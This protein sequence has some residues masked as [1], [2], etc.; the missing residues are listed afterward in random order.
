MLPP[1][2]WWRKFMSWR[3]TF[4][5]PRRKSHVSSRT[6]IW[7]TEYRI[8]QRPEHRAQENGRS[9]Q[10]QGYERDDSILRGVVCIY[11]T[12]EKACHATVLCESMGCQGKQQSHVDVDRWHIVTN[13]VKFPSMM[14]KIW[15][16]SFLIGTNH[17][18]LLAG[19]SA[20]G[21]GSFII[22]MTLSNSYNSVKSSCEL[23]G[24]V[25]YVACQIVVTLL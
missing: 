7:R 12:L 13:C 18:M 11:Q 4:C 20:N 17:Y 16:Q 15:S 6:A 14:V 10:R 19:L 5:S 21:C 2:C 25:T 8:R 1:N 23:I 22:V 9:P 24:A 3:T